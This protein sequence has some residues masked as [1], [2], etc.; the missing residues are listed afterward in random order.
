MRIKSSFGH[1]K[2]FSESLEV[3]KCVFLVFE[4]DKTEQQYFEGIINNRDEIGISNEFDFKIVVRSFDENGW[5]NPKKLLE[6]FISQTEQTGLTFAVMK[7][8]I[9]DYFL[10]NNLIDAEVK[11]LQILIASAFNKYLACN[12]SDIIDI[13]LYESEIEASI[14]EI[15]SDEN[16]TDSIIKFVKDSQVVYSKDIDLVCFVVDRDKQSFISRR[17]NNQYKYVVDTCAKKGIDLYISN[18][19]FEFWLLLHFNDGKNLDIADLVENKKDNKTGETYIIKELKKYLPTY[20]KNEINFL[21]YKDK[22]DIA[23]KNSGEFTQDII[24]L[25][26]KPGTNI[27]RLIN[28]LRD[29]K[30]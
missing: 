22:I 18:P 12:D 10:S 11:Y 16:I 2:G 21:E 3:R 19:C 1:R 5:S 14:K 27:A 29:K 9:C 20:K 28:V 8:L 4:G 24:K 30:L 17:K 6:R 15:Y 7:E 25:R 26:S 23:I 13:K